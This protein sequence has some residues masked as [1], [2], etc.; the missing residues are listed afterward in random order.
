MQASDVNTGGG[1]E[2]KEQK[3]QKS[4][5]QILRHTQEAALTQLERTNA[6]L[7]LSGL[8]AGLDVGFSVL[9][10]ATTLSLFKGVFPQPAVDFIVGNMYPV[11]FIFVILGRSELFTE[12]TTLAI[13][14][15]LDGISGIK[16]LLRLW[17]YVYFSNIV[18]GAVFSF[19]LSYFADGSHI[20]K[21]WALQEISAEMISGSWHESFVSAMLAGWLMGLL[22]WLVAAARD[23]ISQL[24]LIWVIT[25]S[26][27]I[28]GLH[29]CI[30]GNV[31]VLAGLL[32]EGFSLQ[33]YLKFIIPATLGNIVGG[34]VFVGV[35]KFSH[36]IFSEEEKELP[37]KE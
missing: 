2:Q 19:I 30:A 3:P 25:A 8:S 22:A 31:E 33:S 37:D 26:I 23:T 18:G 7:I 21:A 24:F 29:H 34:A 9:L 5:K 10:M 28:A 6:G 14:P 32:T 17:F 35:L 15:V 4:Q 12:H 27:G 13:L 20:V 36:T 16:Q 1:G 11:G